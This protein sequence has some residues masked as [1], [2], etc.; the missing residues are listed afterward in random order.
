M[1]FTQGRFL[2]FF[3]LV[4]AVHWGLRAHRARKLWLLLASYVFYA[5][6]DWRFL[7]LLWLSTAVDFLCGRAMDRP[8]RAAR[9]PWLWVSLGTSLALLGFFKYFDFFVDSAA[10]LAAW[11][12]LPFGLEELALALPLG[13]SF[14]TFQSMSYSIDVYRGRVKPVRDLADFAL[15]VG[16]FPQIGA[17][18]ITRAVHFLPQLEV[19]RRFALHVDARRALLLFLVGFFKKACLADGIAAAVQPVFDDPAGHTQGATWLALLLYHVQIYCDFSGYTD[20][21]IAAAGL[22]GYRLPPNFDFPYFARGIGEFWRRW[23]ISLAAWMRDYLYFPLVGKHPS[24]AR[25]AWSMLLTMGV[26]GLWHGAGWQF[27]GFGFLHGA[28]LVAEEAWRKRRVLSG[29]RLGPVGACLGLNLLVLLTWPVFRLRD[30]DTA[31]ALYGTLLGLR[32]GGT[33]T[34]AWSGLLLFAACAVVHALFHLRILGRRV[35]GLDV[36]RLPRPA[37]ALLYGL[38]WSLVLPWVAVDL[39]PFLYFQF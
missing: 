12:G 5:C 24:P 27:A 18:P 34:L 1:L 14:Y 26:C 35:P 37:F 33:G 16:F 19:P 23:H 10:V 2:F 31:R 6:W 25:R 21:A 32:A 4:F 36:A 15:F 20:M 39:A 28:Y 29:L 30:L 8:E 13:I 7:S 17:G 11:L 3:G 38:A 9:R 22:L